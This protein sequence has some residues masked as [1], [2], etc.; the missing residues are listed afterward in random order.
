M[1]ANTHDVPESHNG[2][3]AFTLELR[4]S[5]APASGF[6]Y[7]TVRNHAFTVTGGSV[8][9]VRRLEPGKN[10]RREA[11][12]T[13]DSNVDVTIAL[14]PTIDCSVQGA[15]CTSDRSPTSRAMIASKGGSLVN[16]GCPPRKLMLS[17]SPLT[18]V[19]MAFPAGGGVAQG[20]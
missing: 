3:T 16:W 15:I 4:F 11:T 6:S 7:T 19:R 14:H 12:V 8:S 10:V 1:T 2:A 18:V 17:Q 5:E 20:S 13:P 9:E